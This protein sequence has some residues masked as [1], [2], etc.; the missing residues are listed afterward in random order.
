MI[1]NTDEF[2]NTHEI[3]GSSDYL[4]ERVLKIIDGIDLNVENY[5]DMGTGDG[6]LT[7]KMANRINAQKIYGIDICDEAVIVASKKGIVEQKLNLCDQNL[8]FIDGFFDFVTAI[9]VIEHSTNSDNIIKEAFRVIKPGGFFLISSPNIGS[10]LS[11]VSLL[12]GY[13]PPPYEVSLEHRL[14][15]PLGKRIKI[16]LGE[17]P[18][19]HIKPY[20]LRALKEHLEII[21]FNIVSLSST[22]LHG[23]S[24]ILRLIGFIDAF[25]SK[26]SNTYASGIIIV[27][28][29]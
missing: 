19:G 27:A 7:L 28:K 24:G 2:Y 13:M 16:P 5:L 3:E 25:F 14:G 12:F 20:N 9:D 22:R 15:K 26:F 29:K 11:I 21:G 10:W 6:C 18:T 1:S 4:R 17:K 8:P 23:G